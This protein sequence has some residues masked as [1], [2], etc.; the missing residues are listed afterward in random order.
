M[1]DT[2]YDYGNSAAVEAGQD[3][4]VPPNGGILDPEKKRMGDFGS[5]SDDVF[6]A[7]AG[8]GGKR[9]SVVPGVIDPHENIFSQGGGKSYRTVGRWG[10]GLILI[11]NQV[12]IGILSLPGAL[13]DLGIVPG[14]IAIVGIGLLSTYTAYELLQFYRKH[15]YVVNVVDMGRVVG[16]P[17]LEVIV[18]IG[19][20][21]NF[22]FTCA[23]ITVTVTTALNSISD[24]AMCTVGFTAVSVVCFWLLCL[25]RSFSFVAK[26]GIPCAISILAAC[27]IVMISLGIEDPAAVEEDDWSPTINIV[28]NVSFRQGITACLNIAYAYAGSHIHFPIDFPHLAGAP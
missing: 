6:P 21:I 16:G 27:L 11:T 9:T 19:L 1:A 5:E 28:G 23:S 15:P 8:P 13:E 2:T 7:G 24:H 18:A 22:I 10:S 3:P 17:V 26:V 14:V 25:P 20:L 4:N 12:G